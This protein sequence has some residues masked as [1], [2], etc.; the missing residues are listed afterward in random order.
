[1]VLRSG[2]TDVLLD[3]GN[4]LMEDKAGVWDGEKSVGNDR[5]SIEGYILKGMGWLLQS[6]W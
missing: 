4:A 3:T 1:M 5:G 6:S 2:S